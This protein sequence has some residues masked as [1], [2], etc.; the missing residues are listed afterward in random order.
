MRR[1]HPPESLQYLLTLNRQEPHDGDHDEH[2]GTRRES[3]GGR[4]QVACQFV[5]R[6]D[7]AG[8]WKFESVA[9]MKKPNGIISMLILELLRS[10][11]LPFPTSPMRSSSE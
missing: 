10:W 9:F 5:N 8:R 4:Y 7:D 1:L 11:Y 2:L 6:S 3:E